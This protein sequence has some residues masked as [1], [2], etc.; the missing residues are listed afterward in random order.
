M[1]VLVQIRQMITERAARRR[2]AAIRLHLSQL[3]SR[4][5]W[6]GGADA[7]AMDLA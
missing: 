1:R 4:R 3:S 5:Q 6:T 7:C 2:L